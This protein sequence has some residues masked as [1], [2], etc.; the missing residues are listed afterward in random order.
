MSDCVRKP[1]ICYFQQLITIFFSERAVSIA[2]SPVP[3]RPPTQLSRESTGH[4]DFK[5][6]STSRLEMLEAQLAD[7]KRQEK[8]EDDK[9]SIEM[10][11]QKQ[12]TEQDRVQKNRNSEQI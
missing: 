3:S 8:L 7:L 2:T 12:T 6:K 5:S 1:A 9:I 11:K 10:A 4:G